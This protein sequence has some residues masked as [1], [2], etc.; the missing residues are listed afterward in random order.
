[1][2]WS[3]LLTSR[4]GIVALFVVS[5]AG[6][7]FLCFDSPEAT[8]TTTLPSA[9]ND[10]AERSASRHA[11]AMATGQGQAGDAVGQA[12]QLFHIG[13]AGGLQLD[14]DTRAALDTL[15]NA[16]P[17]VPT[18]ADL[19]RVEKAVRLSLPY[20]DA[21][22]ALTL[23]RGYIGYRSDVSGLLAAAPPPANADE[24]HQLFAQID[25]VQRRHFA[26]AAEQALFGARAREARALLEMMTLQQDATLTDE[27]K[28][29]RIDALRG[30]LPP[31]A[32]EASAAFR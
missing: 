25:A 2:S 30:A 17:E 23:V 20:E 19:A 15:V 16:L 7:A 3:S 31:A 24:L 14:E 32:L 9:L 27:Q 6:I 11:T 29:D 22:R 26:P 13:Y 5:A 28:R 21:E 10:D 12:V 8:Q 4:I 1:M 18:A